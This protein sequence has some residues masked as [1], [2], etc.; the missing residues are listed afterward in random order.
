MVTH[1]MG[2]PATDR[3]E[4]NQEINVELPPIAKPVPAQ[5]K[6][7]NDKLDYLIEVLTQQSVDESVV[8]SVWATAK[9]YK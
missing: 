9:N 2:E 3:L 1:K 4:V 5:L 8:Q 7:I 6:E